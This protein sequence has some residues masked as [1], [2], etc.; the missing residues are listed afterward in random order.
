M[1]N[2]DAYLI[3]RQ[4]SG[5]FYAVDKGNKLSV[6]STLSSELLFQHSLEAQAQIANTDKFET[7]DPMD[8]AG[9]SIN[10]FTDRDAS[11]SLLVSIDKDSEEMYEYKMLQL[12]VDTAHT[13]PA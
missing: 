2:R 4:I 7:F 3:W 1:E 11:R 8:Q 5:L 12:T 9:N 6:W 13:P 10:L